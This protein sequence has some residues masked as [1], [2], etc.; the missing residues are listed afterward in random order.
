MVW[1]SSSEFEKPV[2]TSIHMST[3]IHH[4]GYLDATDKYYSWSF[5]NTPHHWN[6][7]L[8]TSVNHLT[9]DQR[10]ATF[11]NWPTENKGPKPLELAISGFFYC[12]ESDQVQCFSCKLKLYN[13]KEGESVWREHAKWESYC[14][15]LWLIKEFNSIN[16]VHTIFAKQQDKLP[17]TENDEKALRLV[18]LEGPPE[19]LTGDQ[20]PHFPCIVCLAQERSVLFKP[21]SH[22]IVCAYCTPSLDTCP[23]CKSPIA[24]LLKT[25]LV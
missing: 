11:K 25:R 24:A 23:L 8:S 13:W 4:L 20:E 16:Y 7:N 3:T 1:F 19:Y 14:S 10:L 5:I 2:L 12:G 21:C 22:T 6:L 17:L 18:N 9:V 15:F